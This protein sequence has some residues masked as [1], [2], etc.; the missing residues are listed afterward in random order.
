MRIT[1]GTDCRCSGW[2]VRTRLATAR[3]SVAVAISGGILLQDFRRDL[4]YLRE[5]EMGLQR[6]VQGDQI[7]LVQGT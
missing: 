7:L 1:D 2:S 3:G 6:V 5:V 4:R